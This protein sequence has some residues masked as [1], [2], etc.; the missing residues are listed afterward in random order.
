VANGHEDTRW[1]MTDGI[2]C[3]IGLDLCGYLFVP[4]DGRGPK[5]TRYRTSVIPMALR[6]DTRG[7]LCCRACLEEQARSGDDA[8]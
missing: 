8:A 7:A 4:V 1:V 3:S 5:C 2:H 6:C